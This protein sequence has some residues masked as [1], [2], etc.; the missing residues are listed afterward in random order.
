MG[1]QFWANVLLNNEC[2]LFHTQV[3][4]RRNFLSWLMYLCTSLQSNFHFGLSFAVGF[5]NC[6]CSV[7]TSQFGRESCIIIF[8]LA[9]KV[10]LWWWNNFLFA[11][12]LPALLRL[13]FIEK[14][15]TF[16]L[17]SYVNIKKEGHRPPKRRLQERD[18]YKFSAPLENLERGKSGYLEW[19]ECGSSDVF[20]RVGGWNSL[21]LFSDQAL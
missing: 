18:K 14:L 11:G 6:C 12:I 16:F 3:S 4:V 21:F 9:Q 19:E 7:R 20:F 2:T 1:E 15:T 8:C 10:M 13:I 5:A 17:Y